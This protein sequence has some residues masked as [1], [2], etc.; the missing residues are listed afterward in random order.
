[1]QRLG[2]TKSGGGD[3]EDD[4]DGDHT[5]DGDHSESD[6]ADDADAEDDD[7]SRRG[8]RKE[9]K[10]SPQVRRL[11]GEATSHYLH[12]RFDEA[13][14]LLLQVIRVAPK[15]IAAYHTLGVILEEKGQERDAL[16]A[17][18][19]AAILD[20]RNAA[21]WRRLA[22]SY[23]DLGELRSAAECA[24]RLQRLRPRCQSAAWMRA[25]LLE[26]L[27][28]EAELR[29]CARDIASR[30]RQQRSLS[31]HSGSHSNGHSIGRSDQ[32]DND[33]AKNLTRALEIYLS[34]QQRRSQSAAV[35]LRA[36]AVMT[37]LGNSTRATKLLEEFFLSQH[38]EHTQWTPLHVQLAHFLVQLY[39]N[40]GRYARCVS[41]CRRALSQL[42]SFRSNMDDA[43]LLRPAKTAITAYFGA[44]LIRAGGVERGVQQLRSLQSIEWSLHRPSDGG[45]TDLNRRSAVWQA[46]FGACCAVLRVATSYYSE[47]GDSG[48][49]SELDDGV[50]VTTGIANRLLAA[51]RDDRDARLAYLR[52]LSFAALAATDRYKGCTVFHSPQSDSIGPNSIS[53]LKT[54]PN[55]K[56]CRNYSLL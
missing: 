22:R 24:M 31:D 21:L 25:L 28:L 45:A 43:T 16:S 20:S 12:S 27:G 30:N 51:S 40:A 9:Q 17:Y 26:R 14:P 5:D 18:Q 35:L 53:A 2:A 3:H 44:S 32:T 8:G 47:D 46:V 56:K 39:F 49:E 34:L 52:A 11:M 4:R 23:A 13:V 6:S 50:V 38:D 42:A 19:L 29:A 36:V 10:L 48:D 37:R 54:G 33:G 41:F 7:A 1:M 55:G 15:T